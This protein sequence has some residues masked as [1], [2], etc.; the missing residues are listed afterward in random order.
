MQPTQDAV[1]LALPFLQGGYVRVLA[2]DCKVYDVPAESIEA[3]KQ[4][5]P[6]LRVMDIGVFRKEFQR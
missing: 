3:A 5:D 2:S 1:A 4:N 6:D